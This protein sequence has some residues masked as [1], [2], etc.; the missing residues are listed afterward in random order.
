MTVSHGSTNSSSHGMTSSLLTNSATMA[1]ALNKPGFQQVK[2]KRE[3]TEKE[4]L[5]VCGFVRMWVLLENTAG[6]KLSAALMYIYWFY[7]LNMA[8]ISDQKKNNV[9]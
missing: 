3:R 9:S 5:F 7:R 4:G 6:A 2:H 8:L 1:I